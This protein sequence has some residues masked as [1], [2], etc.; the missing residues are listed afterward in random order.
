MIPTPAEELRQVNTLH[1]FPQLASEQTYAASLWRFMQAAVS[2]RASNMNL[3]GATVGLGS[4]D[5]VKNQQWNLPRA[6]GVRAQLVIYREALFPR[7]GTPTICRLR[8]SSLRPV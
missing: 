1:P 2:N 7:R 3:R 4:R 8:D 6:R 5:W